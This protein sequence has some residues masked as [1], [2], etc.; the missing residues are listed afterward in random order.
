MSWTENWF[1]CAIAGVL[2]CTLAGF[3]FAYVL[4]PYL[5]FWIKK[6]GYFSIP[7]LFFGGVFLFPLWICIVTW[8][9]LRL[10]FSKGGCS[11]E[12]Q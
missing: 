7:V 8:R 10:L 6:L 11:H 2:G 12:N 3:I 5:S 9:G 4:L 1:S